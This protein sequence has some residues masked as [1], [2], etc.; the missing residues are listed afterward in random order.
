MKYYIILFL[1]FKIVSIS[2]SREMNFF[3]FLIF[4]S[5]F[6]TFRSLLYFFEVLIQPICQHHITFFRVSLYSMGIHHPL[7]TVI[8]SYKS[9]SPLKFFLLSFQ[10]F[11][12]CFLFLPFFISDFCHYFHICFC[13]LFSFF[14]FFAFLIF[15][16]FHKHFF[17]LLNQTLFQ[18]FFEFLVR[19][20]LFN[21]LNKFSFLFFLHFLLLL[22]FFLLSFTFF[23]LY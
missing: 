14:F 1:I 16:F 2:Y 8:P 21:L 7:R 19:L 22:D 12:F 13:L 5:G 20:F 3:L 4:L 6:C 23:P 17:P 11:F 9:I 18:P 10:S 15:D